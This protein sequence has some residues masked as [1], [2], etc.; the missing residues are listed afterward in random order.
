MFV[1][2]V[3]NPTKKIARY[4]RAIAGR[5]KCRDAITNFHAIGAIAH[6]CAAKRE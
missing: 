6:Y 2:L 1:I 5:S 3:K 4:F